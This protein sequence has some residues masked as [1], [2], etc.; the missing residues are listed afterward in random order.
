M[1]LIQCQVFD[2]KLVFKIKQTPHVNKDPVQLTLNSLGLWLKYALYEYRFPL[3]MI[4]IQTDE[5]HMMFR[6]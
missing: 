1:C 2:V 4:N 3:L 6:K 5:K